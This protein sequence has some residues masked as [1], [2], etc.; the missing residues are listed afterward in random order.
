MPSEPPAP[1]AEEQL[2]IEGFRRI[3]GADE[4]GRGCLAGPVV[5]AAV[6]LP[7]GPLPSPLADVADS[8]S[9]SRE[10]RET[11]AGALREETARHEAAGVG[12]GQCSPAEID[13]MNILRAA[14]EAM[15]RAA[16]ALRE[17][18]G[19]TAPGFLLVDGDRTPVD[20]PCPC[21]AVVKGDRRIPSIAAASIMAKT[22]RDAI[23]RR[24][25]DEGHDAYGWKTNVGY[26]TAE[27]YDGLAAHGP[28]AHHRRSFRLE[29]T[30]GR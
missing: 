23:M 20:A 17:P 12:V 13:E 15:R 11:L 28:T 25:H 5:A 7:P 14:L 21:R 30:T 4:A 16:E 29:R 24:L 27:H 10:R 2:R 19:G 22:T 1:S 26:P 3:A 8:K 9:L 6:A 18:L